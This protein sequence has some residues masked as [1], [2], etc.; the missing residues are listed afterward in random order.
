MLANVFTKTFQ[1]RWRGVGIASISLAALLA[2]AMAVYR[3]FDLSFYDDMPEVFRSMVGI[4]DG[5]D[6][7]GLSIGVLYGLY[8]AFTLAGLAISMGSASIAGEESSGT[9]GL[10]LGNPKSRTHI[11]A[12]KGATLVALSA[13]GTLF[14]WGAAHLVADFLNVSV[15]GMH[16]GSYS[17]HL[18]ANTLFYGFLAFA[19]GAWTGSR[20]MASGVAAGLMIVGFMVAG[21][22]PLVEG[23][24]NVAKV[25]PWYYF[26][27][28]DPIG[29][30][31]SWG[32]LTVLLGGSALLAGIAQIGLNR[33]DLRSQTVGENLVDRL[34]ANPMTKKVF[35]RLAGSTRVS[36][37]WIKTA[38][39]H[40]GL[41]I[42]TAYMMF[43]LMGVLMGP[44]YGLMDESLLKFSDQI[45]EA[46]YAFVGS[47]GG[48]MSTAEGFYE[49][50]TF[51]MMAPIAVIVVGVVIGSQALAGE[52]AKRTMGLLLSNPL[53]RSTVVIE[54]TYAMIAYAVA[55]GVF[56]WAGVWIGSLLGRLGMSP[57]N[58]A[59][60]SLLATLVGLVFGALSLVLSA[61]TGRVKIAVFGTV[62]VALATYLINSIAIL[63]DTV[64]GLAVLS[65]FN[66]YLT[67][68]PLNTGMHWGNAA[69]L[70]GTTG[71]LIL[72]AVWLFDRRD[73]RQTG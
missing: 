26:D 38:S 58:I 66:Y 34:R 37:I 63:N 5:A 60:A 21:I 15:T 28:A 46:M 53:K 8:G 36:R 6:A 22:A 16:V 35:D 24:E 17:F 44:L 68:D 40:Q 71:V 9:M 56:T 70:L 57:V 45:P 61:A 32:H 54:K 48:N 51:G 69:V 59:A 25:F 49:L 72:A 2:L 52:E 27:G 39:E 1:D 23:W 3:E 62:G 20:A 31:P 12:S 42:I 43:F 64:E 7:A 11:L 33:R 50:E 19:I 55:V 18:F 13:L 10:L 41:L 47:S 14:L 29:N 67:S 65:P 73:L 4:P 30:G